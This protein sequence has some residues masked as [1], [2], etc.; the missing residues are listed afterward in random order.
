M[1]IGVI[2]GIFVAEIYWEYNL[3]TIGTLCLSLP[4]FVFVFEDPRYTSQVLK[5]WLKWCVPIFFLF[6]VFI[7]SREA[8][9]FYFAPFFLF[10]S[11]I[12]LLPKKWRWITIVVLIVM[13]ISSLGARSQVIKVIFAIF[14]SLIYFYRQLINQLFLQIIHWSFYGVAIVFLYL[15][16]TGQYN[17]FRDGLASNEGKYGVRTRAL[18]EMEDLA[19]DTRTFIYEEVITSA[20]SNNY[21]I[22]GRTPARGNDSMFFDDTIQSQNTYSRL[23]RHINEVCH[24]NIFTW[25][26]LVGVILYSFI[27]ICASWLAVYR[28]KSFA[29]K[30]LGCFIAFHWLFGWIEDTNLFN[31]SNFILWMVIAMGFSKKFREMS[32]CDFKIWINGIFNKKTYL[33]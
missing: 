3:L 16:I 22:C 11:F 8:Y 29:L 26:G 32:D 25:L 1:F 30:I 31:I 19:A 21:I 9:H 23:E 27:Y 5:L 28:S 18:N 17:I 20:I 13:L 4:L 24:P 2:R 15:G 12:F 7:L 33:R 6:I 14:M 10:G